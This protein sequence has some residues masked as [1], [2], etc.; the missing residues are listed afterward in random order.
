MRKTEVIAEKDHHKAYFENGIIRVMNPRGVI[1][2]FT[3]TGKVC[4]IWRPES[5][6]E[7][8]ATIEVKNMA[9]KKLTARRNK[10]NV[11]HMQR[12]NNHD[13]AGA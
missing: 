1:G 6:W 3:T 2:E 8:N 9:V 11:L 10:F 4:G 7:Q 5:R 12:R 13:E